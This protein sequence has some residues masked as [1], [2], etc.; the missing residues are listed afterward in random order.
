MT[1]PSV[2][3]IVERLEPCPFCGHKPLLVSSDDGGA[4]IECRTFM[5][6]MEDHLIEGD[7]DEEA[8]RIWNTRAPNPAATII[9]DLQAERDF[10]KS[11]RDRIKAFL[12][13]G[14]WETIESEQAWKAR[15]V[16]A[17]SSLA[18]LLAERSE[19][20]KV[21]PAAFK[22]TQRFTGGVILAEGPLHKCAFNERYWLEEPLFTYQ[23]EATALLNR[24]LTAESS[25][26]DLQA[27]RDHLKLER[28]AAIREGLLIGNAASSTIAELR[29]SLSR[30]KEETI[31][32]VKPFEKLIRLYDGYDSEFGKPLNVGVEIA[33][34]RKLV[35]AIRSLDRNCSG[36]TGA[37]G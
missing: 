9:S 6:A 20:L 24:A 3:S 14:S 7:S 25:V 29:S 32:A 21:T 2:N 4:M 15:A 35:S 1:H 23:P 37:A 22:R 33:D 27:E 34:I 16:A 10:W 17:E 31:E 12:S 19:A 30:I 28:S 8:A 26:A 36:K 18:S 13:E 11:E 5:C